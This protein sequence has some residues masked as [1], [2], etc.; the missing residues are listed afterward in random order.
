[1]LLPFHEIIFEAHFARIIWYDAE[2]TIDVIETLA[3]WTWKEAEHAIGLLCVAQ[4][5]VS[6]PVY[7]I[8]RYLNNSSAL[9]KGGGI[10]SSLRT[11]IE[12]DVPHER[13]VILVGQNASISR[14]LSVTSNIYG[15]GQILSK[16]RYVTSVEAAFALIERDK[17]TLH[18]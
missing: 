9:P 3:P 6:H 10:F 8:V 1:M 14:F 17:A 12:Y 16:Y 5:Q 11:I 7:T 18:P 15:L 2:R 13:L 4:R